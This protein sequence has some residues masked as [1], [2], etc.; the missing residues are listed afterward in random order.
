MSQTPSRLKSGECPR[1]GLLRYAATGG[2]LS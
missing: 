2:Q 1:G